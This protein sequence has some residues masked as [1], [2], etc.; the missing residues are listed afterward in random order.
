MKLATEKLIKVQKKERNFTIKDWDSM[1]DKQK[2][3]YLKTEL[4]FLKH[5]KKC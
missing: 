1:T 4:N 3:P 2:E 5:A